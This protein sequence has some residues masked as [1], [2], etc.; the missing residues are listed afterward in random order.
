MTPEDADQLYQ[1]V[2]ALNS[3]QLRLLWRW[4]MLE[5]LVSWGV[6]DGPGSS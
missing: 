1:W 5:W 2:R 4:V 3:E 6:V